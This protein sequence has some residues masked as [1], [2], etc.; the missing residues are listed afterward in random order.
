MGGARWGEDGGVREE[1]AQTEELSGLCTKRACP[2]GRALSHCQPG[3]NNLSSKAG[4]VSMLSDDS[5]K[6]V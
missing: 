6:G 5:L 2:G 4:R 3:V 1:E